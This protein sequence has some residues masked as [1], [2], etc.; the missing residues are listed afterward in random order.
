MGCI[1][2]YSVLDTVKQNNNNKILKVPH[3]LALFNAIPPG[4]E[5]DAR[6]TGNM[7][8]T[9]AIIILAELGK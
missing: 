1:S 3:L 7:H 2:K 9:L 4:N 8:M 6:P 5:Y